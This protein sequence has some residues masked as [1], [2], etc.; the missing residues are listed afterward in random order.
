MV[1]APHADYTAPA[2]FDFTAQKERCQESSRA[3]DIV[4][5]DQFYQSAPGA[6]LFIYSDQRIPVRRVR[7]L[8]DT[9]G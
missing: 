6:A 2:L 8:S 4:L 1:R 5:C 9:T 3:L 7:S